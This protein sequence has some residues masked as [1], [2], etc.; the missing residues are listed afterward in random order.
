VSLQEQDVKQAVEGK[1]DEQRKSPSSPA[2]LLTRTN[3]W[4]ATSF[5]KLA[6]RSLSMHFFRPP[7]DAEAMSSL[8]HPTRESE[9]EERPETLTH[10]SQSCELSF[11]EQKIYM[12]YI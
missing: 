6:V 11:A 7:N 10:P 12:V 5:V 3:E 8:A 2:Q 9:T 4:A 1:A